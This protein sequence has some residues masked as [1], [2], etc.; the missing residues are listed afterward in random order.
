MA[1]N[2]R[3]RRLHHNTTRRAA[4]LSTAAGTVVTLGMTPLTLPYGHADAIDDAVEAVIAGLADA[5]GLTESTNTG[6]DALLTAGTDTGDPADFGAQV[7]EA[8]QQYVYQPLHTEIEDWINDPANTAFLDLLNQPFVELFGRELIGDG[9]DD[10]TGTN[11]SLLGSTGIFGD[12][13]DGG[14]LF[15]DGGDGA[16]GTTDHLAGM[17]GGDAGLFRSEEHTSELQSRGHLVCRLLLE[18]THLRSRSGRPAAR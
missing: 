1:K 6:I 7:A 9:L 14:F 17:T 3:N 2:H 16:D 5:T 10:F 18:K 8:L 4:G 13:G 11:D 12:L 15:G